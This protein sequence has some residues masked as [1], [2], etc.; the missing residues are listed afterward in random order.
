MSIERDEVVRIAHLA[1]VAVSEEEIPRY[2]LEL[3]SIL[4][5]VERINAAETHDVAPLAHPLEMVQ[6]L[7][8]D[9]VT[10]TIDRERFQALAPASE[11][12][13]YLVPRVI[14]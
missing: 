2:A 11:A 1:R 6:R 5:L 4:T 10:E 8:E 3:S 7:R 9:R 13:L 12:G 14:E